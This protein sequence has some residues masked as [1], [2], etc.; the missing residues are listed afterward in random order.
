MVIVT[1]LN[2]YVFIKCKGPSKI[3]VL[4]DNFVNIKR[5]GFIY[6]ITIAF[7]LIMDKVKSLVDILGFPKI[8]MV[9]NECM[10]KVT[11][12]HI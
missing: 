7:F 2:K 3:V 1:K 9:K 10:L 6:R 5:K 11:L 4:S 8:K 12:S